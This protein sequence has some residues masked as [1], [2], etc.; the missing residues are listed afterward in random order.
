MVIFQ[1]LIYAHSAI[2][3]PLAIFHIVHIC[4]IFV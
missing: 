1:I 2:A 4:I 3:I